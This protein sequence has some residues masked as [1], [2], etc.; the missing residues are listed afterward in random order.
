VA[1]AYVRGWDAV[2]PVRHPDTIAKSLAIGNPADGYYVLKI[3]RETGG[4]IDEATDAEIAAGVRLLAST[5]G[6]F[7]ETAG[8]VTIAV[9]KKLAESGVVKR[10]ERVVAYITGNGLKTPQAIAPLLGLAPVIRP[11]LDA[12]D[13]YLG[14][15]A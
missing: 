4:G 12:F 9:L 1:N 14:T 5:E 6:I 7:A 3:V 15:Q 10:G 13:A 8:G 2:K 11:T